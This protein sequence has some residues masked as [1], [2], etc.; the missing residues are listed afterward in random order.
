MRRREIFK[1]IGGMTAFWALAASG[2]QTR[3]TTIGVLVRAAPGWQQFWAWFREDLRELGYIEG[4]NVRFEF[5]SDEGDIRRLP[6]LA[7]QLVQLQVDVIVAWFTPAATAAKR[8]THDIPIV[9]AICG[10]LV[11]TGLVDSLARP[12]GN[13]TGG[14]SLTAEL[15]AKFIELIR[16]ISP[17][18]QRVAVL[19]NAPDPFSKVF[20][21]QIR[22]AGEATG[23]ALDPI[24]IHS[25]EEL[26][27]AFL[28]MEKSRPDAVIVQP[29]LPTKRVAELALN[30]RI[31]AICGSREFV[32]NGGL[33]SYFA[34]EAEMYRAAAVLVDKILKGANPAELPVEQPTRF[35]LVINLKTAKAI[36]LTLP[37]TF[38][39]R[40][41]A[42]IE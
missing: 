36:G 20:V 8:A 31:P 16:E 9:C 24:M 18:A 15:S 6:E 40:A 3:M 41:D 23:M 35:E 42:I 28:S 26:E 5:R 39:A 13:L 12:G 4:D 19:A 27:G 34:V 11:G 2:Q 17:S 10:D 1:V 38:L 25:P 22:V 7:A 14:S 21:K 37:A 33:M 29:S 32:E 30:H